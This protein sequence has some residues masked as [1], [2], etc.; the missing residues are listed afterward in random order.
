MCSV[1]RSLNAISYHHL[2]KAEDNS[3]SAA[4]TFALV[5]KIVHSNSYKRLQ[6]SGDPTG[7]QYREKC[8]TFSR[9]ILLYTER[10]L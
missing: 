2:D 6:G 8:L 4:K 7:G 1:L 10:F 9:F 5:K 3:S